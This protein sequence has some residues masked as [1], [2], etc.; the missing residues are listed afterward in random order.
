MFNSKLLK[1]D[2][3]QL[4][5]ARC[6]LQGQLVMDCTGVPQSLVDQFIG[7]HGTPVE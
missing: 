3:Q 1:N 2:P 6:R 4:Y 7:N 5:L